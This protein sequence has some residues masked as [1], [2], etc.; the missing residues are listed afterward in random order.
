MRESHIVILVKIEDYNIIK[1]AYV[2]KT[3]NKICCGF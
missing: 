3:H 2:Y 1:E